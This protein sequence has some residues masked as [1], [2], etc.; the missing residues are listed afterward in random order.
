MTMNARILPNGNLLLTADNE[1]RSDIKHAL[2]NRD[3]NYWSVMAELFEGYAG[4]GSFTHFD[5]GDANPFV[6]LTSAPCIAETMNL[7]DDGTQEIEGRFWYF[8]DY[9][10][11]D[12]LD[13]LKCKGRVEYALADAA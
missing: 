4:N 5:G 8:A 3:R 2:A 11:V 10:I 7:L 13:E 9:C 12:D 1:T 6:G